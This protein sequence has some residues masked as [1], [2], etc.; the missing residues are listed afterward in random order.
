M[1]P[2]RIVLCAA[3][4]LLPPSAEAQLSHR[5][6]ALEA[7]I[8]KDLGGGGDA[9]GV[10][11]LRATSWLEGPAEAVARLAYRSAP[12]TSGRGA[13]FSGTVG[14]RL[15]A[16]SGPLRPQ[17]EAEAG[18]ARVEGDGAARDRIAWGLGAGLEW[19]PAL[20]LSLALWAGVRGA[21]SAASGG[22]AISGGAYF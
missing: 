10:V 14:V 11:A 6:I 17:V 20:D 22:A 5:S 15:S 16:G 3:A 13:A 21:G 2:L 19:F 4:L 9:R 1:R 18:W 8:S 12:E 7:G